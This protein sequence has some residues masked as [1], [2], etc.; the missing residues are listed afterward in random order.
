MISIRRGTERDQRVALF[1]S[2]DAGRARARRVL[3]TASTRLDT[4]REIRR[5]VDEVI[6][7][8]QDTSVGRGR[9]PVACRSAGS[10]GGETRKPDE[11][12]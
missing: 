7:S 5:R 1:P 3:Q 10:Q 6:D 12:R 9:S 4:Q 8:G 11:L 2:P